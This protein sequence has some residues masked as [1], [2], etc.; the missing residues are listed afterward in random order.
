MCWVG[1]WGARQSLAEE[2]GGHGE[3]DVQTIWANK[4][5][6]QFGP[7]TTAS[8]REF[9]HMDVFDAVVEQMRARRAGRALRF[10][11]QPDV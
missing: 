3:P 9:I 11:A 1:Y 2:N 10:E 6:M 7:N 5:C 8:S 4:Q